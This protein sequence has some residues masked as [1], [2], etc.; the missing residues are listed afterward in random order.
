MSRRFLQKK[1]IK[2]KNVSNVYFSIIVK[3]HPTLYLPYSFIG[4]IPKCLGVSYKKNKR[5]LVVFTNVSIVVKKYH[6]PTFTLQVPF[7]SVQES[8]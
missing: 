5:T 4:A 3:K 2:E 6:N 7:R 1:I 8:L